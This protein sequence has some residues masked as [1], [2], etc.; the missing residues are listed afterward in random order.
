MINFKLSDFR[1]D[2]TIG[3][4]RSLSKISYIRW[5]AILPTT[6]IALTL[7]ATFFIELFYKALN[8]VLNEDAVANIVG[9]INAI[10]L[11]AIIMVCAYFI[12]PKFKFKSCLILTNIFIALQTWHYIDSEYVRHGVNPYIPF[13]G[14]SYF[15]SLYVVYKLNKQK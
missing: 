15:L 13:Y 7:F 9:Y 6:V 4:V 12:S 11:P 14:V 3:L 10:S 1:T 5:I 2:H 8:T